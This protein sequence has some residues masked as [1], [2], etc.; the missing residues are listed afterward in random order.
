MRKPKMRSPI[1]PGE[2]LREDVLAPLRLSGNQLA[3]GLDVD[4][5]RLNEI[6]RG[7]QGI[8]ADTARHLGAADRGSQDRAHRAAATT[9]A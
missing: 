1:H 9:A 6:V 2:I 5:P 4:T 7:R 8:T 3:K